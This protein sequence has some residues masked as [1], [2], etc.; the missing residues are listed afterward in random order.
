MIPLIVI[1]VDILSVTVFFLAGV[2]WLALFLRSSP[3]FGGSSS[4]LKL[5]GGGRP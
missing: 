1:V 2:F 4:L 3:S 5:Q